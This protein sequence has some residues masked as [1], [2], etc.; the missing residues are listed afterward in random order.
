MLSEKQRR[1]M[2]VG[3]PG[4]Q[5]AKSA[6]PA[7]KLQ[8]RSKSRPDHVTYMVRQISGTAMFKLGELPLFLQF[9]VVQPMHNPWQKT[10][11][12]FLGRIFHN[13][14]FFLGGWYRSLNFAFF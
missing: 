5:P 2:R 9:L 11:K 7:A 13:F 10:A 4:P 8:A 3:Q 12:S 1:K 6:G 14:H